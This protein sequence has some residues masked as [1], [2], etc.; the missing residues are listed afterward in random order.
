MEILARWVIGLIV[1]LPIGGYS[2]KLFVQKLR[3]CLTKKL[4]RDIGELR[5]LYEQK[6]NESQEEKS[7][8]IEKVLKEQEASLQAFLATSR[9]QPEI[10][11]WLTGFIEQLFF[12]IVVAFNVQG[13]AIAMIAWATVKMATGWNWQ[14]K[15]E[16]RLLAFTGLLGT[17]VSLL[18]AMLGGLICRG[19]IWWWPACVVDFGRWTEGDRA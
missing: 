4:E 10:P 2:T 6:K 11:P 1:S 8:K 15:D 7:Q 19:E 16:N 12:T 14:P 13:A 18:F 17:I 5:K 3:K 9:P